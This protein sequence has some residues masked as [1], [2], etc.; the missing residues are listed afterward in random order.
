LARRFGTGLVTQLDRALGSAPEPVSPSPPPE[1]FAVR[2]SLPDPIGLEADVLAALD[3]MIPRLCARLEARGR[4]ARLLRLEAWRS[5]QSLDAAEVGLARASAHPDRLRP[6]LA[7]KAAALDAG[8]GIDMLRLE[9]IR[10]EPVHVRSPVGHLEAGR[11]VASRLAAQSGLEDLIGRLGARLGLEAITRVHPGESHIPEKS[12]L[13]L[14]AAWS[15]PAGPWPLRFPERPLRLWRPEPVLGADGPDLP[16]RFR[17]RG[18]DFARLGATG[19]ERIAPEWWLDDP[20][21]RSGQR[22]YWRVETDRG[23]RLWLFY[24]HGAA[25]SPGWFC[26][27]AFA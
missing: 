25:L 13:T 11:A 27:G 22:D 23:D 6:L 17:W 14:A 15:E 7:V 9:A 8:F 19:P 2:L 4:G 12:A 5:D 21:W 26:H 16:A 3:R 10:H 18:R 1:R 20:D 24:A